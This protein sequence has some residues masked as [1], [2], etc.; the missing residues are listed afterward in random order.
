MSYKK[1]DFLKSELMKIINDEGQITDSLI[2]WKSVG[3][4]KVVVF[5]R[6][7]CG[8]P[9]AVQV[10]VAFSEKTLKKEK[11]EVAEKIF[12]IKSEASLVRS[13]VI[14]NEKHSKITGKSRLLAHIFA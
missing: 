13:L 6:K 4:G 14:M 10:S 9:N 7:I 11:A 2:D 3:V 12:V 8:D 5:C 1:Q